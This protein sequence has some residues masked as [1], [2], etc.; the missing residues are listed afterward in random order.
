MSFKKLFEFLW[1]S[2]VFF[3]IF[4]VVIVVIAMIRLIFFLAK[5]MGS[6]DQGCAQ[7]AR[8]V[9]KELAE[10]QPYY[11][12]TFE[13][14]ASKEEKTLTVKD[15]DADALSVGDRGMLYYKGH[16]FLR[17]VKEK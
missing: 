16:V 2:E 5:N 13:I 12:I 14:Q 6:E 11:V 9:K 17:F 10:D 8:V 7:E 3:A 4:C 1:E 15:A